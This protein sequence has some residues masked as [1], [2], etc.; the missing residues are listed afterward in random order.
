LLE[1]SRGLL[2]NPWAQR[3]ILVAVIVWT[4]WD[5]IWAGIARADQI[6][7]LHQVGQFDS[8]WD[9]VSHS[10]AWNRTRPPVQDVLLYRPGSYLLLGTL[11]Y[12]FRYNFI[13]WQIASLCA[14][15]IVVLGLHLLL[16]RGGLRHTVFPLLIGLLFGT[17]FLSSEQVLWN[18]IVGYLLFCGLA[19]YATYFLVLYLQTDHR[20]FL[21]L[22]VVLGML[23]EFT[24]EFGVLLNLLFAA[25]L[26]PKRASP[27]TIEP[28][29]R[30]R[31]ASVWMPLTFAVSAALLPIISLID[32]RAR[33][34]ALPWSGRA[35]VDWNSASLAAAYCLHQIGRWTMVWLLPTAY[36][37]YAAGRAF[38]TSFIFSFST[39]SVV[40]VVSVAWLAM[41]GLLALRSALRGRSW[42]RRALF[43][44]VPPLVFLLGY[45]LV[46]AVGRALPRGL[47]FVIHEN[48]YYSYVAYLTIAVAIALASLAWRPSASN[49]LASLDAD[50]HFAAQADFAEAGTSPD[51]GLRFALALFGLTLVNAYSSAALAH[52]FRYHFAAATQQTIDRVAAW[53]KRIG[54]DADR[55]FLVSATC[56]GSE[57]L[58]W[59]G[60]AY[61][62]KG[63]GWH[64]PVSLADAL[65]PNRSAR[66]NAAKTHA[67]SD[68]DEIRCD[69]NL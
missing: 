22:A 41:A 69:G 65:W 3:V 51:V 1:A 43:A 57:P 34:L 23:A 7:Y 68:V 36:P 17:A 63:S 30:A 61:L 66:L 48:V 58:H 40:N 35:S 2:R 12:V 53:Q 56:P 21:A 26:L 44:L 47:G 54:S 15:L 55:Y 16:L 13:E 11:Y 59:F 28:V 4:F 46:I 10:F 9:I 6:P 18:H 24:Y 33:G 31:V 67:G 25:S 8:L 37:I 19:V 49:Q 42:H 64:P 45:S 14:H 50:R 52:D 39:V 20:A 29:E 60:E 27:A 32:L 62:R 5:G 38:C